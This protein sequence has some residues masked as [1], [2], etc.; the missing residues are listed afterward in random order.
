[1][2]TEQLRNSLLSS[3]SHDLRTPLAA[4][5]GT[6]SNLREALHSR[7]DLREQ[8]MLQ[9][10]VNQSHQLVRLV[11]NLLDMAKLESGSTVLNR[12]WHVLEELIGSAL[13]RVRGELCFAPVKVR[14][15]ESFP[16]I[17]V[18]GFLLE[19]AFVNLLENASRY[20]PPNT[21]IEIS[22]KSI[23]TAVLKFVLPTT[24]LAFRPERKL[25]C[26]I[27]SSVARPQRRTAGAASVWDWQFARESFK[28]M[29]EKSSAANRSGGGAEF[30]IS[31][32]V[33]TTIAASRD[34]LKV[35]RWLKNNHVARQQS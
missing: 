12:Q 17:L 30:V 8:E 9:T 28:P 22:A 11:E 18:D 32:S 29:A 5:A 34:W 31:H 15:A 33:Q 35:R 21:E 14:I 20:T 25:K 24:A 19:Q 27:S 23:G 6:A 1:M 7:T 3:V 4:I 10:L 26:S 2:Q 16:L 13:A